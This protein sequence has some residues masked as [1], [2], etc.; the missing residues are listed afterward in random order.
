MDVAQA[1]ALQQALGAL[2]GGPLGLESVLHLHGAG[3]QIAQARLQLVLGAAQGGAL[4]GCRLLG[5]GQLALQALQAPGQLA[6]VVLA[7]AQA[8]AQLLALGVAFAVEAGEALLGLDSQLLLG[9]LAL[10]DAAQLVLAL[11]RSCLLRVD[12]LGHPGLLVLGLA[13]ALLE[14]RDVAFERLDGCFGGLG[15]PC[16]G[17][18]AALGGAAGA[19]F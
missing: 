7:G 6:R 5:L 8:T 13:Q 10:L 1:H 14:T 16:Q 15:A 18:L 12:Q 19:A 4:G 3:L 9:V 2:A 17:H 11:E